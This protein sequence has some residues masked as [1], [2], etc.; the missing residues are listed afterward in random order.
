MRCNTGCRLIELGIEYP[1]S[2][3]GTYAVIQVILQTI[4]I[5]STVKMYI[6]VLYEY[7]IKEIRYMHKYACLYICIY[8]WQSLWLLNRNISSI[9]FVLYP[10]KEISCVCDFRKRSSS[11]IDRLPLDRNDIQHAI[12]IKTKLSTRHFQ[13]I[14][15][16]RRMDSC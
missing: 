9:F 14:S 15:L 5:W 3:A 11:P 12:Q 13:Y 6:N 10:I 8:I 1:L 7:M 4:P 2:F 16:S